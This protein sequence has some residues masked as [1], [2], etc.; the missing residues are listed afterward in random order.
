M[1]PSSILHETRKK[2]ST[3]LHDVPPSI[4][5]NDNQDDIKKDIPLNFTKRSELDH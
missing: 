3:S 2:N 4:L 5:I 1:T